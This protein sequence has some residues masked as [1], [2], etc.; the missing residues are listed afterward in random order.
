MKTKVNE[1]SIKY[2][3]NYNHRTAPKIT[4]SGAAAEVLLNCW[5]KDTIEIQENFKILLLNNSNSV[6][7]VFEAS[8]GGITATLVDIRI[9]FA[10]ILKSLSVSIILGHNH[11]SGTL[12]PSEADKILTQKIISAAVLFDIKVL[13]HLILSSNGDY[14]SFANEGLL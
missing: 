5:N 2:H 1:I 12:I 14:Y 8:T 6:K 11:P 7:G 3:G 4:S 9:V 13:D 10:V